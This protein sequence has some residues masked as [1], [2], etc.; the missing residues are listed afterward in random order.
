MRQVTQDSV[1]RS[2]QSDTLLPAVVV[3]EVKAGGPASSAGIQ[4]LFSA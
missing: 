1:S 4:V 2:A 3:E